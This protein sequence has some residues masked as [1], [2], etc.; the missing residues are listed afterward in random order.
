MEKNM[1]SL[2]IQNV[3]DHRDE[4]NLAI[5]FVETQQVSPF[6]KLSLS[7]I[8]ADTREQ[9]GHIYKVGSRSRGN[10]KWES[11]YSLAKPFLNILAAGAGIQFGS[12]LGDVL[13]MDENTWKAFA[14]GAIRL[15]DGSVRTCNDFKVIDLAM[16][17]KRYR[18]AYEE[19]AENGIADYKAAEAAS[20]KYSGEW[21]DTG[22]KNDKGYPV[23]LYVISEAERG[24]YIENS[25]LDA[26]T[27]LR[28]NAPQKAATGAMLRVIRNLIGIKGTYTEDEL[29]KPFAVARI[30]F[31]SDYNDPLIRQMM[32]QQA[33]QSVGN[34]FGSSQQ[35][36][37]IQTFSAPQTDPEDEVDMPAEIVMAPEP[38]RQEEQWWEHS[39][40]TEAER[41]GEAASQVLDAGGQKEIEKEDRSMDFRCDKCNE[42]I[43]QKVWEYSI[44][45]YDRPLC[46]KC[47]KIV[48]G[49]QRGGRR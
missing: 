3:F 29:K 43:P 17:E 35:V 37:V 15:P 39:L 27:Q 25:L 9:A 40:P 38:A 23:R 49:E 6:Y 12:G 2:S 41:N 34:L 28:A 7:R 14:H 8:Y 11:L 31:S 4:Y 5:P 10:N 21:V 48:R 22:R 1:E 16:E 30:S 18:L 24:R 45:H 42:V 26:M 46:Y 19:K 13:K 36:P 32:L 44:E 47:Q 33:M 20:Q